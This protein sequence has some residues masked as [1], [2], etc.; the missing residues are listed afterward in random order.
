MEENSVCQKIIS[1]LALYIDG[2]LDT[3]KTN[4]VK[5]H[6]E[7]CPNCNRRFIALKELIIQIRK[8]YKEFQTDTEEDKKRM[9]CIKEYEKFLTNLSSY[10]DNELSI[11]ESVS[12][13]KYMIKVPN[14]RKK[15]EDMCALHQLID[16]TTNLIKQSCPHDFSRKICE[17][18]L[19]QNPYLKNELILKLASAIGIIILLGFFFS[20][21]FSFAK[22]VREKSLKLLKKPFYVQIPIN[23]ELASDLMQSN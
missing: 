20:S 22:T 2:K 21:N 23:H 9:F 13:K 4:F 11:N 7:L 12:M 15:L 16:S 10:F 14:A 18:V 3:E 19:G 17:K 1:L 6:I 5:K 8:A